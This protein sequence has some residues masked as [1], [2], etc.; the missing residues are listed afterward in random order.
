MRCS[1]SLPPRWSKWIWA[2]GE[3]DCGKFHKLSTLRR[4]SCAIAVRKAHGPGSDDRREVCAH[5][6]ALSQPPALSTRIHPNATP[7]IIR[8]SA[9]D[10]M[11]IIVSSNAA[12]RS[13]ALPQSVLFTNRKKGGDHIVWFLIDA[14][15]SSGY[16]SDGHRGEPAGSFRF[17]ARHEV[18]KQPSPVRLAQAKSC[19]G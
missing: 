8:R 14:R 1:R 19:W 11:A 16:P 5:T 10:R 6:T 9:F 4:V 3:L 17:D 2:F 7:H 18:R 15:Y 12:A 13:I